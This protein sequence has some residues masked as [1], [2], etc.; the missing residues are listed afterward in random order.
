M[1]IRP[2]SRHAAALY[3]LAAFAAGRMFGCCP[4]PRPDYVIDVRRADVA[5][6]ASVAHDEQSYRRG[7]A[8]DDCKKLCGET[9]QGC[10]VRRDVSGTTLLECGQP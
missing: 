4:T 3:A 10:V 5:G 2:T 7:I 9:V 8:L 6:A 1:S